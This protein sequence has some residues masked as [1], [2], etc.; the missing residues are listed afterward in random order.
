MKRESAVD[1]HECYEWSMRAMPSPDPPGQQP[2]AREGTWAATGEFVWGAVSDGMDAY[3]EQYRA[4]GM[5]LDLRKKDYKYVEGTK[6][7]YSFESKLGATAP[8]TWARFLPCRCTGCRQDSTGLS[9]SSMNQDCSTGYQSA[10]STVLKKVWT[11]E[12][13]AEKRKAEKEKRETDK[14]A[15]V[16]RM[17]DEILARA[18]HHADADVAADLQPGNAVLQALDGQ[19]LTLH[20]AQQQAQQQQVAATEN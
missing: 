15:K 3:A 20:T 5:V 9:C 12:A 13:T 17:R 16:K 7:F 8:E 14:A 11:V 10:H 2:R 18:P 1:Y 19:F 6:S 4:R